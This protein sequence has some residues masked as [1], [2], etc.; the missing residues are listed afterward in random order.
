V[1]VFDLDGTLWGG[2]LGEDGPGGIALGEDGVGKCY[3]DLQ[4]AIKELQATGVL[5]AVAS[6]NEPTDVDKVLA[7]HPMMLIRSDDLAA[8]RVDWTDKVTNIAAIADDL[9]LGLDSFV[10][11]DDNPVE[12]ALVSESLPEVAV[13]DFP[14][15]PELLP[16]WFVREVVFPY[17]PKL[18][19]LESDR[20]KT[21]QYKARGE[22]TR[23]LAS[24]VDLAGFLERLDMQLD[25]R[26]DDELLVERAAQ[27]TQ[28]TN[29]FNL[30]L[31]RM[32]PGEV[33]SM[34]GDERYAVVTLG[35]RDRF[36]DEG[37]VGLGI[38]DRANADVPVFLLSCRVIGR[39][40]EDRLLERL[41]E[42]ATDAGLDALSCTFV[43]AARN[44]VAA[45]FL[46]GHGWRAVDTSPSG[47]ITYRW[48]RS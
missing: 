43:P 4:R 31:R 32:T 8:Q 40:V 47:E 42:L 41:Q 48:E 46:S 34:V 37:V 38:L 1:L 35:Y 3:R 12:R 18:R 14:E 45:G 28:K 5:L 13:P 7:D 36:A 17:F 9:T 19:V 22:R 26:V 16:E 33:Q 15:R 27:M 20:A 39:G 25:L 29:Q 21:A 10:F 24:S 23:E 11:L 30:T 2:V 44:Q 6:K